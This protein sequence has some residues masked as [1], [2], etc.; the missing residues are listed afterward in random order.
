MITIANCRN[1]LLL[2]LL[3]LSGCAS[4]SSQKFQFAAGEDPSMQTFNAH[5]KEWQRLKP[6]IT[7]LVKMKK[8]LKT[9]I[10]ELTAL[11]NLAKK[12]QSKK[13][14]NADNRQNVGLLNKTA[15]HAILPTPPM[16][17]R[18]MQE[19]SPVKP[20][21]QLS[22]Q[23]AI[24]L[25][26]FSNISYVKNMW[27]HIQ[28]KFPEQLNIKYAV[29]EAIKTANSQHLFRL[30][31]GPYANKNAALTVCQFLSAQEQN[32]LVTQFSGDP[33]E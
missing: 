26:S 19:P 3:L 21:E 9:L 28:K 17:N 4:Q 6:E 11:S 13:I 16:S 8:E 27:Q 10:A 5:L 15:S 18:Q 32:C 30:K 14:A 23:Y 25:G 24:Q 7:E 33:I 2:S 31:V 29:T 22:N 1:I 20:S 12:Q